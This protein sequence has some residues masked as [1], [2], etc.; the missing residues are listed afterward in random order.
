MTNRYWIVGGEYED[1]QFTRL[2]PDTGSLTGP[3][4]SYDD[5]LAQW[6]QLATA[7]RYDAH[8]RYTIATE[9]GQRA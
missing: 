9:T 6:R 4:V 3:Y 8:A 1:T 2:K 7:S 5:A